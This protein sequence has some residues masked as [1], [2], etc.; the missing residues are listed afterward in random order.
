MEMSEW[1]KVK[2]E[3]DERRKVDERNGWMN[4]WMEAMKELD[5]WKG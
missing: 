2:M 3:S 4:G 1:M 5:G